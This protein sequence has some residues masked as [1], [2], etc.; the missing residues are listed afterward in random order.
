MQRGYIKNKIT[1]PFSLVVSPS[2][3]TLH[4]PSF[5]TCV[6]WELTINNKKITIK[7][8]WFEFFFLVFTML[9]L[10]IIASY[11]I[12]STSNIVH[13]YQTHFKRRIRFNTLYSLIQGG[14]RKSLLSG[15]G[16]SQI[17]L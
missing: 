2:P 5:V 12:H 8:F 3:P 13:V 4:F 15:Q 17:L 10:T 6:E 9:F 1:Q 11:G 14:D 7:N 16:A